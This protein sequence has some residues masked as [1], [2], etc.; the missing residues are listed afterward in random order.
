MEIWIKSSIT[1]HFLDSQFIYG[2]L[3]YTSKE[4]LLKCREEFQILINLM[5]R[6][7]SLSYLNLSIS[8]I[9]LKHDFF[10]NKPKVTILFVSSTRLFFE[11]ARKSEKDLLFKVNESTLDIDRDM[12]LMNRDFSLPLAPPLPLIFCSF[13]SIF[14]NIIKFNANST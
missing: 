14:K 5:N 2:F 9:L 11:R 6:S 1:T 12:N 13:Q 7:L 3:K 8:I 4:H 10:C